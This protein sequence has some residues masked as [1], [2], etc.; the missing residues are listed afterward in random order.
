MKMQCWTL[1]YFLVGTT[2]YAKDTSLKQKRD[3]RKELNKRRKDQE[4]IGDDFFAT[5]YDEDIQQND[6]TFLSDNVNN[7]VE[8][9]YDNHHIDDSILE[10]VKEEPTTRVK[11]KKKK[12]TSNHSSVSPSPNFDIVSKKS[13]KRKQS[14]SPKLKLGKGSGE[15]GNTSKK[16]K[17]PT[18]PKDQKC[19]TYTKR[20]KKS[21]KES[22]R[23]PCS[24]TYDPTQ[25]PTYTSADD[26]LTGTQTPTQTPSPTITYSP[27]ACDDLDCRRPTTPTVKESS[28]A[29]RSPFPLTSAP[30]I[31]PGRI[32]TPE[33]SRCTDGLDGCQRPTNPTDGVSVDN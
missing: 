4:R 2:S 12:K 16:D 26:E 5:Y 30:I 7:L 24:G 13:S 27:T 17:K 22:K 6:S 15:N 32:P 28:S 3:K 31:S 23:V 18:T 21:K 14:K 1:I 10:H 20:G 29:S 8:I 11:V 19:Y 9:A 25:S 33:P